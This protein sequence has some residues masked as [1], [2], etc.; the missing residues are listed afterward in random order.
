M[1]SNLEPQR[2]QV[3]KADSTHGCAG[4]PGSIHGAGRKKS[5]APLT[6]RIDV[7]MG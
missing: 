2:A 7:R 3:V 1:R 5:W 4:D 6:Y